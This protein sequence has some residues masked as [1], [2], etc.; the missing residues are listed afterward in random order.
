MTVSS[1]AHLAFKRGGEVLKPRLLMLIVTLACS[2]LMPGAS[3]ASRAPT[4]SERQA[5]LWLVGNPYPHGWAHRIVRIS[6]VDRRWGAV[7]IGANRGHHSQVQPDVASAYRLKSGR[8]VIHQTGNGGGCRMP[9]PVV[10]DL[11]LACY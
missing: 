2:T 5:L 8:W 11:T 9:K 3:W 7:F 10:R 1:D 4:R 6:T